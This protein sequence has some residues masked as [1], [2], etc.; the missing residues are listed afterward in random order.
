MVLRP[1]P[2]SGKTESQMTGTS[3]DYTP[4][5][6]PEPD[7]IF[8]GTVPR[9]WAM[10]Y[11]DGSGEVRE[12]SNLR[13]TVFGS[14]AR[15]EFLAAKDNFIVQNHNIS[16]NLPHMAYSPHSNARRSRRTG[17]PKRRRTTVSQ[18]SLTVSTE[19]DDEGDALVKLTIG[20]TQKVAEYYENAFR[21]LQQLNCRLLAKNFIK[22]IE[23]RK[24]VKHPYNG[25]KP[26]AG[27]PPGTK[28][29]P[30][31]TKPDWWPRDVVHR[32]P[33]HIKKEFRL[34]LLVHIVQRLLPY[35]ITADK[36]EETANDNRRHINP[37]HKASIL[38]E[39]FRVRRLE[40]RYERNEVDATARI[41]VTDH[42]GAKKG[43]P[44]SDDEQVNGQ[45]TP[46]ESS[47]EAQPSP[48]ELSGMPQH[49][50]SLETPSAFQMHPDM[51]FTSHGQPAPEFQTSQ[52]ELSQQ[53][54]VS[55]PMGGSIL[56][57]TTNQFIDHHQFTAPTSP[58][59]IHAVSQSSGH[60]H[61]EQPASFAEWSPSFQQHMFSPV[62]FHGDSRQVAP[63]QMTFSTYPAYPSPHSHDVSPSY[64]IPDLSRSREVEMMHMVS[65]PFRTGSLSHP[66][67]LHRPDGSAGPN[68]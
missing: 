17:Q 3:G 7:V 48:R 20:D 56:T 35:G 62:Q 40:E 32:E 50:L 29:D 51:S 59:Q 55:T 41:Y 33:D 2:R 49:S 66:H 28:G 8:T 65:L 27:S 12:V 16:S 47:D 10:V 38:D 31:K 44:E 64:Q 36:L 37:P 5:E 42:E 23:P 60:M 11:L 4:F 18:E 21:R 6:T 45:P 46:P 43:E 24:Q 19:A 22:L 53:A 63:P 13:T 39:L 57:P 25:G 58:D 26:P 67:V 1:V 52:P 30:E 68:M 15:D 54:L 9:Y 61:T 34:K 14:Q